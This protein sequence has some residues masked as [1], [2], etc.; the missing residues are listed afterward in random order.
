ML[1]SGPRCVP[2]Q[3]GRDNSR[4]LQEADLVSTVQLG[5]GAFSPAF[6]TRFLQGPGL[7]QGPRE[8][9][10]ESKGGVSG[11][12]RKSP[13][14]R[15]APS[16]QAQVSRGGTAPCTL[17]GGLPA[18]GPCES[19][20]TPQRSRIGCGRALRVLWS[21][22]PF[23]LQMGKPRPGTGKGTVTKSG[24]GR[25]ETLLRFLNFQHILVPLPQWNSRGRSHKP[26]REP[27]EALPGDVPRLQE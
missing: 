22:K 4:E 11:G 10:Q 26:S 25:A 9:G 19:L 27:R 18:L 16:G 3:F 12:T 2:S 6:P 20:F 23:P 24:S 15:E 1:S 14:P 21:P 7:H 17:L 5:S 8:S 13:F